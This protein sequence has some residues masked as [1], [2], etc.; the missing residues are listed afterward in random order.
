MVLLRFKKNPSTMKL[1]N[2][3]ST[4]LLMSLYITCII[5]SFIYEY[6]SIVLTRNYN[7]IVT[8][9]MDVVRTWK[10][11]KT[12]VGVIPNLEIELSVFCYLKWRLQRVEFIALWDHCSGSNKRSKTAV[13]LLHYVTNAVKL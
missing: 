4:V 5:L 7:M 11:Y 6:C 10:P 9:L 8:V 13:V 12:V 3:L 1:L 2:C